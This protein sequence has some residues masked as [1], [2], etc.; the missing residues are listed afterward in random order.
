SL[1]QH[2]IF[3]FRVGLVGCVQVIFLGDKNP[4]C[5]K[6]SLP[7]HSNRSATVGSTR[8]ARPA[9]NQQAAIPAPRTTTPTAPN[10]SGS[11]PLP[12]QTPRA[13]TLWAPRLAAKPPAKP[14]P[15]SHSPIPSTI[16]ITS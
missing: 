7:L 8:V 3:E 5:H 12:P 15:T 14:I 11:R 4:S 2:A 1:G 13:S 10:V 9:G 16:P 6:V